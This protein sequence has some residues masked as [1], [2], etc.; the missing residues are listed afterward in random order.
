MVSDKCYQKK[1]RSTEE[2]RAETT[3]LN[4]Q[5][6][7]SRQPL[8]GQQGAESPSRPPETEDELLF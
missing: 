4:L 2:D 5:A 1:D 7:A 8:G 6:K 3:G